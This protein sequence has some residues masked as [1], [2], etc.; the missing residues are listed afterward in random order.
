MADE[1]GLKYRRA[2]SDCV[3]LDLAISLGCE[4]FFS[5]RWASE[6]WLTSADAV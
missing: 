3:C 6:E 5:P 2:F 1:G 4:A